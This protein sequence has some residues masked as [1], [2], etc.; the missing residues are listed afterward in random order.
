M[1][2]A[3]RE[4]AAAE[5]AALIEAWSRAVEAKNAEAM[6]AAYTPETVL[7]EMVPPARIDGAEAIAAMWRQ[8]L[9]MFPEIRRSEHRGLEITVDGD[10]AFVH[11]L[12][13][14]R[15]DPP[16]HPVGQGW[17]RVTACYRRIDGAWRVLHEHVSLPFD[18]QSGRVAPI[19]EV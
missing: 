14:F 3:S 7:F 13:R 15:T 16:E 19:T 18:P 4:S 8:V 17:K 10:L 6:V 1:T 5:I 2:G 9:P 11:G 12:H